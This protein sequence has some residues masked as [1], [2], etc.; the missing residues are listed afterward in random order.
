M[1]SRSGSIRKAIKCKNSIGNG[2]FNNHA[3]NLLLVLTMPV[4]CKKLI[5]NLKAYYDLMYYNNDIKS[6]QTARP[7]PTHRFSNLDKLALCIQRCTG[8]QVFTHSVGELQSTCV[9]CRLRFPPGDTAS[10]MQITVFCQ[11]VPTMNYSD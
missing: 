1:K 2:L 6:N 9:P 8:E 11:N 10:H 7:V 3:A 4:V 5:K